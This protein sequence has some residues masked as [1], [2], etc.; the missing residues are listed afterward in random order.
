MEGVERYSVQYSSALPETLVA[1]ETF[2][3][4]VAARPIEQLTIGAPG[5]VP[6]S[7]K[8]A[9]AGTSFLDASSR[10]VLELI[11]HFYL[12]NS[13]GSY[14]AR[15]ERVFNET[16]NLTEALAKQLRTLSFK[17]IAKQS[18]FAVVGAVCSDF[19]MARPTFGTAAAAT[20][21]E[22][23]KAAAYEAVF[24]WRNM[25][26]LERN[27]VDISGFS[28]QQRLAVERYRGTQ[29][30]P[31]WACTEAKPQPCTS[32]EFESSLANIL[33]KLTGQRVSL[34]DMASPGLGIPVVRAVVG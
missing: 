29:Q 15:G 27:A 33:V 4:P 23:A 7:T 28:K 32:L 30:I 16:D 2:G 34:F 3:G 12:E 26:E 17:T 21:A 11:E 24:S 25:V 20:W 9:A 14:L 13:G 31:V 5:E 6:T 22:A 10:A 1:R 8:G 19:N 18:S